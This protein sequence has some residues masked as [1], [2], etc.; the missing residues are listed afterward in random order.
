MWVLVGLPL[1]MGYD[2]ESRPFKQK[3]FVCIEYSSEFS[4]GVFELPDVGDEGVDNGAP[5]L[6]EGL[7]PNGSSKAGRV[8]GLRQALQIIP[9]R[10]EYLHTTQQ[11]RGA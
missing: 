4:E 2:Q 8:K 9:P 3:H 10:L 5:G 1:S 7:I 6:V 11:V